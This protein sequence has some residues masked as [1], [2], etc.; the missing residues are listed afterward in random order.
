[1]DSCGREQRGGC[2]TSFPFPRFQEL[3]QAVGSERSEGGRWVTSWGGRGE[4]YLIPFPLCFL[5]RPWG[6]QSCPDLAQGQGST[7]N[8]S[9]K[10]GENAQGRSGRGVGG[11]GGAGPENFDS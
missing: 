1:M 9:L 6:G 10:V 8:V 7:N 5:F 3:I 4:G 2:C 11:G